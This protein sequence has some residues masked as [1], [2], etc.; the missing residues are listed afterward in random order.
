MPVITYCLCLACPVGRWKDGSE[1]GNVSLPAC[2]KSNATIRPVS[3]K[4]EIYVHNKHLHEKN[5]FVFY[6][7]CFIK[8][9]IASPP[10]FILQKTA[11][12]IIIIPLTLYMLGVFFPGCQTPKYCVCYTRIYL[13]KRKIFHVREPDD[14]VL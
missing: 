7:L 5:F 3:L 1:R 10:I 14:Y 2:Q 9:F 6:V 13:H 4:T 11:V 12:I 8:K